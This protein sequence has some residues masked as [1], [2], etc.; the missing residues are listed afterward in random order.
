[1]SVEGEGYRKRHLL[2]VGGWFVPDAL[3]HTLKA[4]LIG[5]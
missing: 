2:V 4:M 3:L 1:M 5:N